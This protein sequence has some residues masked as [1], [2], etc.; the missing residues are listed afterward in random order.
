MENTLLDARVIKSYQSLL[1]LALD[2]SSYSLVNL[3]SPAYGSDP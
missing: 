1:A 2:S 3:T